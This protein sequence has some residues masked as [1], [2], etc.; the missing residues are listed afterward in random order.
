ME[1]SQ[2]VYEDLAAHLDRLPAGFPRTPSGVEMRILK[3]LFTPEEALLAQ[4][5][6]FKPETA[7]QVADRTGHDAAELGHRLEDMARK[8]LLFRL[9]KGE[10]TRYMAA[11]FVVGIWEYHVND[12]DPQLIEDVNEYLPHFF[13]RVDRPRTPQLRT[14]P[15]ARAL[16]PEQTIMPYDEVRKIITQQQK[17]VLAP[18]I[19]RREHQM[20]GKGCDRPMEGCLVFGTGAAYYE[21]NR[22]GR[23][24]DQEEA[25]RVLQQAEEAGL[26]LQPS[27]A[28]KV[29]NIC[30]CCGC[31][32]QILKNLKRLPNPAEYV[33]SN[34]YAVADEQQCIGC[35]VCLDRCQMGAISVEEGTARIDRRYC[36]GCGLCVPTCDSQAIQLLVK[37]PEEQVTPPSRITETYMQIAKERMQKA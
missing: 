21:D 2:D 31:C 13:R 29:E 17:I 33:A 20:V 19:C 30:T 4:S 28:Q 14:I 12:L 10:E 6:T 23:V 37:Q 32:C 8:G 16:T 7:Q 26:V 15:I 3:R 5:M 25:L 1:T 11:Q 22:L 35:E 34:Y 9:R 27:N 18:C 24:I 36:I